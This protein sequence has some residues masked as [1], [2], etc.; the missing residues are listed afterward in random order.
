MLERRHA[1]ASDPV[2]AVAIL[3]QDTHTM[4]ERQL[5][6]NAFVATATLSALCPIA[7]GF[8]VSCDVVASS[9]DLVPLGGPSGSA[10]GAK[11]DAGLSLGRS[12]F[13]ENPQSTKND[14]ESSEHEFSFGETPDF[15][16]RW[17]A[18]PNTTRASAA[19]RQQYRTAASL[20]E[21]VDSVLPGVVSNNA[22]VRPSP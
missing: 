16:R 22:N 12:L 7:S 5:S 18:A 13:G 1:A 2:T 14:S 15:W 6:L 17:E 9:A 11:E 4:K 3:A 19:A 10:N 8:P 20:T 21:E